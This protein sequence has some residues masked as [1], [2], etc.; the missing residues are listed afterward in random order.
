MRLTGGPIRVAC[1]ETAF[2]HRARRLV[3]AQP[4]GRKP[5]NVVR[6]PGP[7]G[8]GGGSQGGRKA[9][10]YTRWRGPTRPVSNGAAVLRL[11][12]ESNDDAP[13]HARSALGRLCGQTDE[14]VLERAV[15]LTS[16]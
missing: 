2:L 3:T 14:D 7:P 5:L 11:T 10:T 12:L 8:N 1:V 9:M 4:D 16:E 6:P 13:G 15:L